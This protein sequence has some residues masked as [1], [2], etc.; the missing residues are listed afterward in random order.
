MAWSFE[1]LAWFALVNHQPRQA[2]D[3]AQQGLTLAPNTSAGVQ[4]A[5]QQ[6]RVW[7]RLGQRRETEE[8]LRAGQPYWPGCHPQPIPSTTSRST[9]PS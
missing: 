2:L 1:L 5:M 7:A 4:L 9:R 3:L 6:A 8:A